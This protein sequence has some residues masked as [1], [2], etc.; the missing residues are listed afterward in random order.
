MP[1]MI[2]RLLSVL[3]LAL[4]LTGC[5][6][7]EDV[8]PAAPSAAAPAGLCAAAPAAAAPRPLRWIP[9]PGGTFQMG[10]EGGDDDEAPVHRRRVRPFALLQSEVTVGQYR[11]CLEAG[12]CTVPRSSP[13]CNWGRADRQDHPVNC[14]D[15]HQARAFCAWAGGTL[16][17]EA[18]WEY[19]ARGAGAAQ[20]YPW[21][22][23][24]ADCRRAVMDG[25][26]GAGCGRGSTWPVCSKPAGSTPGGICDLAGNLWEWVA[27]CWH[28]NYQGAP[29]DDGPW[30]QACK[31][32]GRQTVRGSSWNVG[33]PQTVRAAARDSA[34]ATSR[35]HGVGFRCARPAATP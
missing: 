2:R 7:A 10:H 31:G 22:A 21:G 23:A 34:P 29:A 26:E 32:E 20:P 17:S 1:V 19:A 14:V 28:G 18:Q 5:R 6:C 25:A 4:S 27:D 15:L 8:A 12:R 33:I 13:R 16:P 3:L 11:R 35:Y 30:L 9:L 24:P